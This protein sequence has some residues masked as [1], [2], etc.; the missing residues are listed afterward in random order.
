MLKKN[1]AGRVDVDAVMRDIRQQVEARRAAAGH[2]G[3]VAVGTISR[4]AQNLP[5]PP[6]LHVTL[7]EDGSLDRFREFKNRALHKTEVSRRIPKFL[8]RLFRRQGGFNRHVLDLVTFLQKENDELGKRVREIT[9]YLQAE[10]G[11]FAGVER[12]YTQNL[13]WQSAAYQQVQQL[14][15]LVESLRLQNDADRERLRTDIAQEH[16]EL[17][18]AVERV[19]TALVSD[20]EGANN[21][22]QL[23]QE[24]IDSIVSALEAVRASLTSEAATREAAEKRIQVEHERIDRLTGVLEAVRASLGSEAATREAAEKRIQLEHERVD[25]LTVVLEAVRASLGSEAATREA[26]EKRIQLEHERVDQLTNILEAVRDALSSEARERELVAEQ[27]QTQVSRADS[28]RSHVE[29]L[30][31][32]LRESAAASSSETAAVDRL[33][34]A[35]MRLETSLGNLDERQVADASYVKRELQFQ[36]QR[37]TNLLT[38][39]PSRRKPAQPAKQVENVDKHQFDAFYLAFENQFRGTRADIKKRTAV[40]LPMIRNAHLGTAKMPVLDLGCGRGEWIELLQ[41]KKLVALGVDLNQFMVAECSERGL[42]VEQADVLEF[43]ESQADDTHGAITAFHLI[44]HLPF[45]TQQQFFT[46]C[47]RVLRP[48]GLCIFET[49]NPDN[50]QVGSNRFYSDPTHLHPLPKDYTKFAMTAVGFKN[51]E[52]LPLHPDKHALP[53]GENAAP[54]EQFI[55]RMFFGEQDYAVIARK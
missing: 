50:V 46:Q 22:L 44:E 11:W 17:A 15:T 38:N 42:P 3:N 47:L 19:R 10:N 34:A 31:T 7:L 40:Y 43:L 36:A 5:A 24:R 51:V 25:G 4:Q 12:S 2:I 13:L 39:T 27:L 21:R 37:L 23:Q 1:S 29:M 48:G 18:Q 14:R 35:I 45:R 41:E 53:L 54:V 20:A 16:S 26:A 6:T 9:A 55:N 8:R 32:S 33:N 28:L 49:P 52:L 30:A